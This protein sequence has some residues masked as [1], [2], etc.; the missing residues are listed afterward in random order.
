M[1]V[2]LLE[3]AE[4]MDRGNANDEKTK[5]PLSSKEMREQATKLMEQVPNLRQKIAGKSILLEVSI[6]ILITR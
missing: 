1:A 4:M 6:Q 2:C 3:L 5:Y